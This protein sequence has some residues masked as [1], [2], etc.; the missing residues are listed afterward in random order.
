MKLILIKPGGQYDISKAVTRVEWSG[1]AESATRELSFDYINA[2][3]D[4][5]SLPSVSAGDFVSFSADTEELFYG[6]VFGS[7]RS[8]VIGTI[9]FTA[10]DM[11]KNLLESTGQYNFKDLTAET[12]AQMV[13]DDMQI[14]VRS[15]YP[16]GIN[17]ASMICDN[18]SVYDII[19][20]AY[21]KAHLVDGKKYFPMVYR[22]G[23]AVYSMEWSV[24]GFILSDQVNLTEASITETLDNIVNRVKVYGEDGQQ[25]GEVEDT[26]SREKY[27]TYQKVYKQEKG[28]DPTTAAANLLHVTPEQEIRVNAVGDPNCLSCYFVTVM[29]SSTGLA[30]RYWIASDCHTWEGESYT[31]DLTLRFDSIMEKKES[32]KEEAK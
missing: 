16:T 6:Q 23:F 28:V 5:F 32:T 14:P 29:D 10:F 8:S 15:L 13:C 3:F 26:G 9:T 2:P 18:M 11:M 22:R 21:T 4:D 7:E 24:A 1:S 25:I 17:I 20:A 31:M 19:M 30:G 12:I 27:G